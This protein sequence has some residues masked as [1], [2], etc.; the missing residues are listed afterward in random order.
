MEIPENQK[1]KPLHH[2]LRGQAMDHYRN[3]IEGTKLIWDKA[4]KILQ[5]EFNSEERMETITQELRSFR[6]Y[7]HEGDGNSQRTAHNKLGHDVETV[8]PQ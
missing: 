8:G 2:I 7:C 4:M 1:M 3:E 6:I 5:N